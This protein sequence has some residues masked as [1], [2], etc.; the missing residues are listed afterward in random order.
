MN[1]KILFFCS[2]VSVLFCS[3][4][5]VYRKN[6]FRQH[7]NTYYS[8]DDLVTDEKEFLKKDKSLSANEK[9]ILQ[10]PDLSQEVYMFNLDLGSSFTEIYKI[11]GICYCQSKK[12]KVNHSTS[13]NCPYMLNRNIYVLFVDLNCELKMTYMKKT[14]PFDNDTFKN[15]EWK[16]DGK[17][18]WNSNGVFEYENYT[19]YNIK[20]ESL[21]NLEFDMQK[22]TDEYRNFIFNEIIKLMNSESVIN[23]D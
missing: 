8:F 19:L 18:G 13:E 3:C 14:L 9:N 10:D 7:T 20:N 4:K 23:F 2:F 11:E 16:K 17:Q 22:Y 5:N 15:L 6:S 12:H 21:V 1:K